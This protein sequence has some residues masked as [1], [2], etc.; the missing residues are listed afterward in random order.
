MRASGLWRPEPHQTT[1]HKRLGITHSFP[2]KD[3]RASG[4][5][6]AEVYELYVRFS[7]TNN[8]PDEAGSDGPHEAILDSFM[9]E[10]YDD[11]PPKAVPVIQIDRLLADFAGGRWVLANFSG[12]IQANYVTSLAVTAAQGATQIKVRSNFACYRN[13]ETPSLNVRVHRPKGGLEKLLRG[14][15]QFRVWNSSNQT[16]WTSTVALHNEGTQATAT[17]DIPRTIKFSPGFYSFEARVPAHVVEMPTYRLPISGFWFYD[18]ALMTRGKPL[19]VDNNFFYRDGEVFPI[20]GTTYMA[21]DVHR[22]FLFE[23]NPGVWYQDFQAMKDAGVN[24]VRT[25][26]WTGWKKY[27]TPDGKVDEG[28]I[29]C[30]RCVSL[31]AHRYDIPVIFTF[32]AFLPE[33]WGGLNAYLDRRAV[34]AQ[35]DF[36]AAFTRR[37]ARVNDVIWDFI[38]EPSFCSP[39][40]LWSCRPNYDQYEKAAWRRWLTERYPHRVSRNG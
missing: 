40:H 26:I 9:F 14:D 16:I 19:T 18:E 3:V 22:R 5:S 38:N 36:I 17:V 11:G 37:Y 25:G 13:G 8:E 10:S 33:T 23:P 31:T 24:M 39:K 34:R 12:A 20:T 32:F 28:S 1:Y 30:V 27:M 7:S 2:V 21:S 35:Q 15:C 6:V 29:A 4:I